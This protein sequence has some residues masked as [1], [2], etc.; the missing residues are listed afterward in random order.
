MASVD[1][2]LPVGEPR[3]ELLERDAGLHASERGTEAEVDAVSERQDLADV[4]VDIEPIG[5]LPATLVTVP[6]AQQQ[7]DRAPLRNG[8]TVDLRLACDNAADMRRRRLEAEQF[9]DGVGNQ[10]LIGDELASL[11]GCSPSTFPLHPISRL[12]VSFPAPAITLT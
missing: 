1:V 10:R 6:G 8:D 5:V 9:L 3:E 4:A 11:S 12:V 2:D 7:E